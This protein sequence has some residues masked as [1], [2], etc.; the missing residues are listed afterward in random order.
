IPMGQGTDKQNLIRFEGPG[1]DDQITVA[2]SNMGV[3]TDFACGLFPVIPP[4]YLPVSVSADAGGN[5]GT[6]H[7]LNG[8]WTFINQRHP[9]PVQ[10]TPTPLVNQ[11]SLVK[12]GVLSTPPATKP[13]PMLADDP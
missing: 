6:T 3:T 13:N 5:I 11:K 7:S 9:L 4:E 1:T 8:P 10:R 2:R 12:T